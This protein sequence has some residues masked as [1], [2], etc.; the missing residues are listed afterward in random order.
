[1]L[2]CHWQWIL[3]S[4][5]KSLKCCCSC[6]RNFQPLTSLR[7]AGWNFQQ[8]KYFNGL[9]AD[10][11]A[12]VCIVIRILS[13]YMRRFYCTRE[14]NLPLTPHTIQICSELIISVSQ[15]RVLPSFLLDLPITQWS[16]PGIWT[17]APISLKHSEW[18]ALITDSFNMESY[19]IYICY[20]QASCEFAILNISSLLHVTSVYLIPP[21]NNLCSFS[22]ICLFLILYCNFL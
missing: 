11:A 6:I 12:A 20:L 22:D 15:W 16:Q 8:I 4:L 21:Y 1:M 14:E 2:Q 3:L 18:I 7:R 5:G 19:C 17:W 13:W 10:E 9:A